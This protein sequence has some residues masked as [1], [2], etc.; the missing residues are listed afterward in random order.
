MKIFYFA[1]SHHYMVSC[2][3]CLREQCL[4]FKPCN[5]YII[6]IFRTDFIITGSCDGHI[7]FWKKQEEGV[8]FVKHFRGHLGEYD[9]KFYSKLFYLTRS[10][11]RL[12]ECIQQWSK[13]FY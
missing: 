11:Q 1:S 5:N 8:E 10:N 4:I 3:L 7:K 13:Y 2:L 9:N 6:I 12:I